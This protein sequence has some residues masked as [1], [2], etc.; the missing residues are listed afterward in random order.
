MKTEWILVASREEARLYS[1][2]GVGPVSLISDMGNPTGL[3]RA[4]DLESDAPGRA[5]DN[6]MRARHAY[7]TQES[8]KDR[9]LRNFY[10]EVIDR[11]ERGLYDHEYDCITIMAEPRLLGIIRDLLPKEVAKRVS[12]EIPK[13][14]AFEEERQILARLEGPR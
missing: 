8:S 6:R 7:S 2:R 10:R 14:L 11:L 9:M 5:T 13:D 1:R 12:R 4:Q 3:L